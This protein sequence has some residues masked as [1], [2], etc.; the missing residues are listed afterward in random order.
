M[1]RRS[2]VT[3]PLVVAILAVS[4]GSG[5]ES[6]D[7]TEAPPQCAYLGCISMHHLIGDT[8]T[9]LYRTDS[10]WRLVNLRYLNQHDHY[11]W[12][13]SVTTFPDAHYYARWALAKYPDYCGR[14]SVY[15]LMRIPS[16][17]D[18]EPAWIWRRVE[19]ACRIRANKP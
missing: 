5:S 6:T 14:Y 11:F 13:Y 9:S 7:P 1:N 15:V 4:M 16:G 18:P 10:G 2:L 19:A 12:Q 8:G 17:T 3:S